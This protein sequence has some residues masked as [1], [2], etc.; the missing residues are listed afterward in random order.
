MHDRENA[1]SRQYCFSTSLK[2]GNGRFTCGTYS[3]VD[4]AVLEQ[5]AQRLA[6]RVP[7]DRDRFRHGQGAG[8]AVGLRRLHRAFDLLYARQV[9]ALLLQQ[10]A[11]SH[12]GRHGVELHAD[13]FAG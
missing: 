1:K 5:L 13:L 10:P 11:D 9:D 8:L 6:A 12:R 4:L 2:S 7:R 3:G